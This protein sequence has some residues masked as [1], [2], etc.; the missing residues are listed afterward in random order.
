MLWNGNE[1]GKKEGNENLGA[2]I[3]SLDYDQKEP[4][5]VEYFK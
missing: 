3:H 2:T 4:E 1:W 5:N